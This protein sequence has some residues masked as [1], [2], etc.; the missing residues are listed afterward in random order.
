MFD[1][2]QTQNDMREKYEHLFASNCER[3]KAINV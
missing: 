3:E 1:L 2:R